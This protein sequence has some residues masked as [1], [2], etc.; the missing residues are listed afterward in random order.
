MNERYQIDS[1]DRKILRILQNDAR[2]PFLEIARKLKCSGGTVHSRVGKMRE[3]GIIAGQKMVLDRKK[4]G[5]ELEAFLGITVDQPSNIA[6]VTD[7]LRDIGEVLELH[8]TTGA[9][10]LLCRVT[11][12]NTDHLYR[13]L[14]KKIQSIPAV[15]STDTMVILKKMFEKDLEVK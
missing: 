4:L 1:T 13:L 10:S 5:Y 7:K 8:Y 14:S 11:V 6:E 12:E 2:T 15:V 9:Y 3:L